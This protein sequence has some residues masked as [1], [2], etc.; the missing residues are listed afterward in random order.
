MVSKVI[1]PCGDQRMDS[2]EEHQIPRAEWE[3]N[4]LV[5]HRKNEVQILCSMTVEKLTAKILLCTTLT[6]IPPPIRSFS[7]IHQSLSFLCPPGGRWA[8][9]E[10][11][12]CQSGR[13]GL[14]G[15]GVV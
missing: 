13:T 6:N 12:T 2:R 5:E 10:R 4:I 11:T 15:S 1:L 8:C 7:P 14:T 3:G 9:P